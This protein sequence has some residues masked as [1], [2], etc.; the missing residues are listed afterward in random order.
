LYLAAVFPVA[1]Y[2]QQVET[3][4]AAQFSP[5]KGWTRSAKEGVVI[6]TDADKANGRFCL[7][8]I[9]A[10]TPS[11]GNAQ[12]DFA[13]RW[14]EAIVKPFHAR[15]DPETE[16]K[17]EDGWTAVAGGSQI[18]SD[19]TR[20]VVIMTVF[21]GFGKVITTYAMF[22]DATYVA[23]ID[24]FN[25]TLKL[26]KSPLSKPEAKPASVNADSNFYD[27]D[28]FPD[29]PGYQ[30]QQPLVG[31]LKRT[32]TMS[33]LVGTWETGGAS[34]TSYVSTYSGNYAGTDTI[35]FGETYKI[36][37]TGAF[38]RS[39][40]GRANNHTVREKDSGTVSLSGNFVILTYPGRSTYKYQF[41]AYMVDTKGG[42]VL[43]LMQIGANEAALDA[44]RIS[45]NCGHGKGYVS[46]VSG[47]EWVRRPGK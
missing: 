5:P 27:S 32:I 28:P 40:V 17:T 45:M 21:S 15:A 26:D 44:N 13:S 16:T 36:S 3:F 23:Q 25:S 8:T 33:D 37:A 35:F 47:E 24:A 4:D 12:S 14:N 38:E 34:V 42:A 9:Y 29:K 22:N 6:Y 31:R 10:A 18:D 46:C 30:P 1:L 41:I 20:A 43:S 7:L 11:S 19:G 39:F 2:A